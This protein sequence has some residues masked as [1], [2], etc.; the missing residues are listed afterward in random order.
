MTPMTTSPSTP[1]QTKGMIPFYDQGTPTLPN[2]I[3]D[4]ISIYTD[5]RKKPKRN[6][7]AF[8]LF[9]VDIRKKIAPEVLDSLNPNDKFVKIAELWKGLN[10]TER[11][12]YEDKAKEEKV[13]YTTELSDFCKI[14][15]TQP[16]QRPRNHIKKPCNAYG[17]YLKDMKDE[18]RKVNPDIRMCEVL[19]VVG[20]KWRTLSPEK[21]KAYEEKAEASRKIFKEEVSKQMQTTKKVKLNDN[22]ASIVV[23]SP[24]DMIILGRDE[25]IRKDTDLPEYEKMKMEYREAPVMT[26][27]KRTS[28]SSDRDRQNIPK[29]KNQNSSESSVLRIPVTQKPVYQNHLEPLAA[30]T[31]NLGLVNQLNMMPGLIAGETSI[32]GLKSLYW[33]VEQL[34]QHILTQLQAIALQGQMAACAGAASP[35]NLSSLVYPRANELKIPAMKMESM[36]TM[37][38]EDFKKEE[39]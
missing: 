11:K 15:P 31:F 10:D 13:R 23:K 26:P 19:R 9:S 8:I 6:R 30:N 32:F 3:I 2:D 28:S 4:A 14:Y 5:K 22:S 27:L 25:L 24:E 37:M 39:F 29:N 38:E 20:E 36:S 33:K 7:S 21:K 34:R 16:I 1:Q 17:Y 18:I 12:I 35:I